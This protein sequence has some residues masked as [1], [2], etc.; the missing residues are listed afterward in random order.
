MVRKEDVE[1]F[2][3][4]ME[5]GASVEAMERYYAPDVVVFENR[6]LSRAGRPQ[7]VAFEREALASLREPANVKALRVAVDED[8]GIAF[9]EW[10]IRFMSESGRPMLLEEVGVQSWED[11]LIVSERFY[12]QG[13]VDEGDV[14]PDEEGPGAEALED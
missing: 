1:A 9:I 2:I 14:E 6:E 13:F 8:E 4:L 3:R 10:R 12:Y 7:V 5:S 11:G